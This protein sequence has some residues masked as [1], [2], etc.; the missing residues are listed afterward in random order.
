MKSHS[1]ILHFCICAIPSSGAPE[2]FRPGSCRIPS[3]SSQNRRAPCSSYNTLGWVSSA[4]CPEPE[5]LCS[6]TLNSFVQ[7]KLC[8]ALPLLSV[9][10]LDCLF[11]A[12]GCCSHLD[13]SVIK[14]LYDHVDC[15][16]MLLG[17]RERGL[18]INWRCV[19]RLFPCIP[20]LVPE[21]RKW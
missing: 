19:A 7:N 4:S 20:H 6:L 5:R 13:K 8:C 14:P 15:Y 2:K 3:S 10:F 9:I 12:Q 21:H 17:C 18:C 1:G 16:L 11:I